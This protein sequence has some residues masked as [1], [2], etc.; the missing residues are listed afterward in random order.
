[1][2]PTNF[3]TNEFPCPHCD[4]WIVLKADELLKGTK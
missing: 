2:I 1:M 4:G 3:L